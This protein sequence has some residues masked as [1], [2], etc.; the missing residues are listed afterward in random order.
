M[1]SILFVNLFALTSILCYGQSLEGQ[2]NGALKIQGTDLRLVF[3]VNKTNGQ[4]EVTIDSPDQNATGIKVTTATF[5]YP[6]VKFEISTLSATYEGT[7]S[8][9]GIVGKW[10]QSGT[11]FFLALAKVEKLHGEK[12]K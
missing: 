9:N 7:V 3:H 11:A 5:N 6:D 4:Y 1:K 10:T 12:Q 2:W 8:D